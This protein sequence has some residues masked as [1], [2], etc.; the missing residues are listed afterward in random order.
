MSDSYGLEDR[1]KGG[2][3]LVEDDFS[4]AAKDVELKV[5]WLLVARNVGKV[6]VLDLQCFGETGDVVRRQKIP[7]KFGARFGDEHGGDG[8]G[9]ANAIGVVRLRNLVRSRRDGVGGDVV[10]ELRARQ[11][12]E[13]VEMWRR[14]RGTLVDGEL[15][16]AFLGDDGNGVQS[17]VE[18]C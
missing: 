6:I 12:V 9:R 15:V 7:E 10:G 11:F 2:D 18:I 3:E 17:L 14:S 8:L 13:I 5:G 16:L 1:S 4:S